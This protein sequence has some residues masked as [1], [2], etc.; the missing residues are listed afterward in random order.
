MGLKLGT[1]MLEGGWGELKH[2]A[3]SVECNKFLCF[4]DISELICHSTTGR[5]P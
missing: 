4:T 2:V 3:C 5:I 1:L